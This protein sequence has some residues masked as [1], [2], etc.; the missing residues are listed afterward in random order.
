MR[1]GQL[2]AHYR[3][4]SEKRDCLPTISKHNPL[5]GHKA[6]DLTNDSPV[7]HITCSPPVGG[8]GGG[9]GVLASNVVTDCEND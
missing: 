7:K 4:P 6:G 9:G 8:G 5:R 1:K 3:D 2:R